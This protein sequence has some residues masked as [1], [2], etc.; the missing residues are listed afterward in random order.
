[1]SSDSAS[2]AP[3][4]HPVAEVWSLAW[5]TVI[6]MTS[7]TVMQFT[8][9]LMVG[10]VG[11]T[12]VAAQGN[13]GI[14]S[15]ALVSAGMGIVT[16]V[17]TYVSQNLG[18]GRPERGSVYPWAALWLSLI[19][20]IV[21]MVPWALA[22]PWI[23]SFMHGDAETS[24]LVALETEYAQFL[25]AGSLF[26]LVSR[27]FTHYFFGLHRPKIITVS[28][29]FANIINVV[30]NYVLI[31]G[32]DGIPGFLPGIPG[33][34]ALGLRGA[35]IATVIG[36]FAEMVIPMAVFLSASFNAKYATRAAWRPHR[37]TMGELLKLGWPAGLQ[38]SN[39]MICWAIFMAVIVG[40]FGEDHMTAGWI[41]MGYMHL[42]FM[43][44][45]GLNVAVNAIVGKYIGA[46]QP[47]VAV[48]RARLGVIMAMG[49]MTLC[50]ALFVIFREQLIAIFISGSDMPPEQ[51]A[52]IIKIG[53]NLMILVAVFQTADA[54]GI[55]YTGALRGAGDTVWPGVVTAIYSW[56][57]IIG[58][59]WIAIEVF[60]GL[61]SVGPWIAAA[62]FIILYAITMLVRFEGGRWRSIRLLDED[63]SVGAG[64]AAPL[65]GGL[66]ASGPDAATADLV[67]PPEAP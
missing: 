27:G 44:A 63:L 53:G 20:W 54:F 57:F 32:E 42:S 30:G 49:Y 29:I 50:A 13:G 21:V 4:Q 19:A 23:F 45:L 58:G 14:W 35:A 65:T 60:P 3:P 64:R 51:R 31:F 48:K 34:P 47:D 61:S 56:V 7:F 22:I 67:D 16:V 46:G 18:A 55:V 8:D 37:R 12:E 52:S 1:M 59:G 5:P 2:K 10:Q 33:V 41:A 26:V 9:K 62:I 40:S 43:P 38:F 24:R 25:L 36:M 28:T 15:F 11:P 66:P 6:T 39:E 17:N